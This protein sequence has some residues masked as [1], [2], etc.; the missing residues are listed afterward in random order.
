MIKIF[1]DVFFLIISEGGGG[2]CNGAKKSTSS[3][4]TS[5]TYIVNFNFLVQCGERE[6]YKRETNSKNY[7]Y[8]Y[9]F[10]HL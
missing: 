7:F 8:L 6:E 2:G 3:K 9:L 4:G 10:I 1:H 5:R